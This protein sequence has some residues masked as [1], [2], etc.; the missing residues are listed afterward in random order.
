MTITSAIYTQQNI[1]ME[2]KTS[3]M[4]EPCIIYAFPMRIKVL[5]RI[6]FNVEITYFVHNDSIV[7]ADIWQHSGD[8]R[9]NIIVL[10]TLTNGQTNKQAYN[11]G[12]VTG[13]MT[14]E[15]DKTK[16]NKA[17]TTYKLHLI[18]LLI[19]VKELSS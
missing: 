17:D 12:T 18:S 10:N 19:R 6:Y 2:D 8:V 13:Q 1:I 14:M 3:I 9:L 7:S 4:C 15:A 11:Q 5:S 16:C